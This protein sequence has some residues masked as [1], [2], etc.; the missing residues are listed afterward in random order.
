MSVWESLQALHEYVYRSPHVGPLRERRAWF[1]PA[2]GPILVRWWVLADHI[3]TVEEAMEK[4]EHLRVHGP[5]RM[6]F[7]FRQPF[8]PPGQA[9][10]KAAEVDAEFCSPPG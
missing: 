10:V 3:P 6:A 7:T 2:S 4:L 8:P 9:S 1:E 5:S